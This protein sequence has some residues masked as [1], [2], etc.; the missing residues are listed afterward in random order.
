MGIDMKE[1][2]RCCRAV[3]EME[4]LTSEQFAKR[5]NISSTQT[6]TRL[7]TGLIA[8]PTWENL[9]N[10]LRALSKLEVV[11]SGRFSF[12]DFSQDIIDL[13]NRYAAYEGHTVKEVATESL[14][15]LQAEYANELQNMSKNDW[16]QAITHT[17]LDRDR[18]ELEKQLSSFIEDLGK[19]YTNTAEIDYSTMLSLAFSKNTKRNLLYQGLN[20][21]M[22]D[23]IHKRSC[24]RPFKFVSLFVLHMNLA[25]AT[26]AFG[27]KVDNLTKKG[28][29][30]HE[31]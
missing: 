29:N 24:I 19:H 2:G 13:F 26:G 28:E 12:D 5:A 10:I 15:E 3:R 27:D 21:Q 22:N 14:V 20:E 30:S 17:Y 18:H 25:V 8:N 6:I 4:K 16:Q 1:L 11:R 7:E 23:V 9:D 31:D